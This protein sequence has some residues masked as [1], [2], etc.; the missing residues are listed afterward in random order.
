MEQKGPEGLQGRAGTGKK[1]Q[2]QGSKTEKV[3]S[4][5]GS[6]QGSV[7]IWGVENRQEVVKELLVPSTLWVNLVT[8]FESKKVRIF[9][10]RKEHNCQIRNS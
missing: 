9:N 3:L 8:F 1:T 5:R 7:I 2:G 4:K 6:A 10:G